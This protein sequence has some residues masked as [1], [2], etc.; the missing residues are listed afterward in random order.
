[1][2]EATR[3][4]ADVVDMPG[5]DRTGKVYNVEFT[6]NLGDGAQGR[7]L[8]DFPQALTE[9]DL[10]GKLDMLERQVRRQRSR[11]ELEKLQAEYDDREAQVAQWEQDKQ[12]AEA[13]FKKEVATIELVI[14]THE[15]DRRNVEGN[16]KSIWLS[17]DKRGDFKA[18]NVTRGK[19]TAYD[20]HI[21]AGQESLKK[22]HAER[23]IA[24]GNF[25]T[26]EKAAAKIMAKLAAK[27]AKLKAIVEPAPANEQ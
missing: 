6:F 10:A 5:I 25:E 3:K 26:N 9:A 22:A 16:A 4:A 20:R 24:V 15:R 21:E 14:S 18:D 2:V 17:S 11:Y 19:L 7:I 23:A 27:I 13:A 8:T 12:A 1:M